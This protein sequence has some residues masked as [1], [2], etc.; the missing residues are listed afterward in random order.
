MEEKISSIRR[1]HYNSNTTFLHL[2]FSCL[3]TRKNTRDYR[4][5]FKQW[6]G[7]KHHQNRCEMTLSDYYYF[8]I[9][10]IVHLLLSQSSFYCNP[11]MRTTIDSG[12]KCETTRSYNSIRSLIIWIQ[13]PS[14]ISRECLIENS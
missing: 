7:S 5:A 6:V 8:G 12:N 11:S 2:R 14:V 9:V 13:E 10:V 1:G 3:T 4:Y